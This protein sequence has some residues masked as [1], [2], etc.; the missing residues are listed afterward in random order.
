MCT[1]NQKPVKKLPKH[2]YKVVLNYTY[3]EVRSPCYSHAWRIGEN[4][5][6]D[7]HQRHDN[8]GF[9][10]LL[11]LRDARKLRTAFGRSTTCPR[12]FRIIR[13]VPLGNAWIGTNHNTG[14]DVEG[15]RAL[16]CEKV[17]WDGKFVE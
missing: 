13:V 11:S 3:G 5:A 8:N 9:H 4:T 17:H 6:H 14:K 2:A 7:S 10:C 1:I 15:K 12:L 16:V